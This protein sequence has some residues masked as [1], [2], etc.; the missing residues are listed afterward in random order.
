[1]TQKSK[2]KLYFLHTFDA[3]TRKKRYKYSE[4]WFLESEIKQHLLDH[5]SQSNENHVL[6]VGS[7]EGLSSVFLADNLLD[8]YN[9]TLDCVDPF[10]NDPENDHAEYLK[11]DQERNFDWNITNCNNA[12]KIKVHKVTS[13]NFFFNNQ[14]T[15]NLIYVDGSHEQ[16]HIY[17]D[18]NN[19][20]SVLE[21]KGVLW[22]D[23]YGG[24]PEGKL[25]KVP[26]DKFLR[27]KSGQYKILHKNYQLAIEKN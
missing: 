20:F 9:S 19:A 2:L 22:M 14:R 12:A 16:D 17:R 27:E 18:I 1:M 23:D 25:C 7:F 8:H 26:M 24:G 6:E 15:F 4:N 13:D 5:I 10:L 11:G 3:I 21:T